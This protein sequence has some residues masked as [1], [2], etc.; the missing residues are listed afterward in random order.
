VN[1]IKKGVYTMTMPGDTNEEELLVEPEYCPDC[2]E[3]LDNCT[4]SP[5]EE[6]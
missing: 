6:D 5:D 2:G 4:C 3:T 1:N